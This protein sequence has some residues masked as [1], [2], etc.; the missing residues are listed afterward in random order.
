MKVRIKNL[1]LV[2]YLDTW[3]AMQDF[4]NKRTD[5]TIDEIWVLEHPPVFTQGQAGKAEH[6]INTHHDIPVIQSD[7]GGQITYH[8]PGQIVCYLLVNLRR[9]KITIRQLVSIIEQAVINTL[10]NF[11]ISSFADPNAPGIYVNTAKFQKTLGEQKAK[12][13][14]LG[15]RVRRGCSYH[16][17]ALN[18]K[19]DLKPFSYI[20]PC[21]MNNLP[22]TQISD[23]N[24]K[25]SF[26]LVI[27]LLYKE[28]TVLLGYTEDIII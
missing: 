27:K 8:G 15:L 21:G 20:N 6:I 24:N 28:L 5:E 13:C 1:G 16:G 22:V 4:T 19:L 12:I 3:Q 10:N 26:E 23:L 25:V 9:L 2:P 11:N 18:Y 17:L 7:R 14:S